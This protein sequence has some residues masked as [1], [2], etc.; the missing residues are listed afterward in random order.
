MS[1]GCST[2][3]SRGVS[4]ASSVFLL[5]A[6]LIADGSSSTTIDPKSSGSG[7]STRVLNYG[8]FQGNTALPTLAATTIISGTSPAST[9]FAPGSDVVTSGSTATVLSIVA[10][11]EASSPSLTNARAFTQRV[12]ANLYPGSGALSL[13][14][15]D[16]VVAASGGTTTSPTWM[17]SGPLKQWIYAT[18]AFR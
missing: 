15:A 17:Q 6:W 9:T 8:R 3:V 10:T 16:A 5:V 4:G 13:G 12:N 14:V 2:V 1:F 11:S 7:M 18:L